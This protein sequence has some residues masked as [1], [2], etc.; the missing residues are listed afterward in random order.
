MAKVR[1]QFSWAILTDQLMKGSVNGHKFLFAGPAASLWVL[2]LIVLMMGPMQPAGGNFS[3]AETI[4][5]NTFRWGEISASLEA[6]RFASLSNGDG[7]GLQEGS[8]FPSLGGVAFPAS[9][10]GVGGA[11]TAKETPR[12]LTLE[13]AMAFEGGEPSGE[14]M[15][16]PEN[17]QGGVGSASEG[18]GVS[19]EADELGES[20]D[21][22]AMLPP[23]PLGSVPAAGEVPVFGSQ[24]DSGGDSEAQLGQTSESPVGSPTPE[25]EGDSDRKVD[26]SFAEE[27]DSLT[28]PSHEAELPSGAEATVVEGAGEA[29]APGS[30]VP[31][32]SAESAEGG[33]QPPSLPSMTEAGS[34]ATPSGTGEEGISPAQ[35]PETVTVPQAGQI[36]GE[37][38]EAGGELEQTLSE[39][40][41]EGNQTVNVSPEAAE[42][43]PAG[44]EVKEV[45]PRTSPSPEG[46]GA[47]P[48]VPAV[49]T[50]KLVQPPERQ[51][52]PQQGIPAGQSAPA[53][54]VA[55]PAGAG[56][57]VVVPSPSVVAGAAQAAVEKPVGEEPR[58]VFNFKYQPWTNVLEW[59]ASQAGLSLVMEGPPHGT[60]NY[61]DRR[62]YTVTEAIDLINS[63]LLTK[64][65]VLVRRGQML[66]LV[67]LED[68]IP[69]NLVPIVPES[70]LANRGEHE[71]VSI[72]VSLSRLSVEEAQQEIRNLLGPQGSVVVLPKAQQLLITDTAG[73]LRMIR[74]VLS[75]ADSPEGGVIEAMQV[76]PLKYITP[77]E[78]LGVLR[79]LLGIPADQFISPDGSLRLAVDTLGMRLFVAGK[80]N[81]VRQVAD[82]LQAV[83]VPGP[84]G[85]GRGVEGSLQLE[86]Y[87]VAPADPQT[88]LQVVQTLL[89]GSPGVRLATDA[90]TG[91]LIALARPSEHATI[92]A[93]LEQMR[94]QGTRLEVIPLRRL[95]PQV[96]ATAIT[97]LLAG[98]DGKTSVKV[99]VDS[100]ARQ[101]LV[102]GT[103]TELALVRSLLDK[104]GESG[105]G[106]PA[107]SQGGTVRVL[108]VYG[109]QA[110]QIVERLEQIWPTL[111]GNAIRVVGSPSFIQSRIPGEGSSGPGGP[112]AIPPG[113]TVPM[114]GQED[115]GPGR[116]AIPPGM[117]P[118][119]I[120]PAGAQFS[121]EPAQGLAPLLE[122]WGL[123]QVPVSGEASEGIGWP[124]PSPGVLPDSPGNLVPIPAQPQ[125]IQED[126]GAF[127][128]V[129]AVKP[130]AGEDPRGRGNQTGNS[131]VST[132]R[133]E[134]GN[135]V[136][137][138]NW[139]V[140][141]PEGATPEAKLSS[142]SSSGAIRET[143]DV[144]TPINTTP[145]N[146][147][148]DTSTLV[149]EGG[150]STGQEG[151]DSAPAVARSGLHGESLP[152][153]E[154]DSP[155][156][157][158][159]APGPNGL[160]IASQD[161]E[162]LDLLEELVRMMASQV[163]S[164]P[165]L[166][167]FYLKHARAEAVAEVLDQIFGGGTLA[168]SSGGAGGSMV[169]DLATAAFGEIGGGIVSSLLGGGGGTI[170]PSGTLRI[171]PDPRLN[172]LIVQA[173][174]VDLEIIDQLL[175][176][177]DQ[178]ESP[179]EVLAQPRP[180]VVP[181]YN[182][183][184]SEVAEIV[185]QVY[186]DRLITGGSQQ[187]R[188]G[189]P[190]PQEFMQMLQA[191]RG[192]RG[193]TTSRRGSM[194][195]TQRLSIGVDTRTNSVIVSAPEPLF[196]E[197]K[198]L[199]EELD[200]AAAKPP[201][202]TQV[203]VV[204]RANP[205]AVQQ[206]VRAMLGENV[207][208]GRS[209]PTGGSLTAG[210]T[211]T[212]SGGSDRSRFFRGSSNFGGPGG[213]GGFPGFFRPG[214]FFGGSSP[215]PGTPSQSST[216]RFGGSSSR[217]P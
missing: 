55:Q 73:R 91:N 111:R 46:E 119:A 208:I 185:K 58:L 166:T 11:V 124:W 140:T 82:I 188:G 56:V 106:G 89:A 63:V 22:E 186:Q 107:G 117:S 60:F 158:I 120:P 14:A 128:Q 211:G 84:E 40:K 200:A 182:M 100:L 207:A 145:E 194:E 109:V 201:Q 161:Q 174:P 79:Q 149:R 204:K 184:A 78:A 31:Y 86:V 160:V 199:I 70:E 80:A 175:Q 150:K 32:P 195:Q 144:Q 126:N 105:E 62:A 30:S 74:E 34:S 95:D 187:G 6:E 130:E 133:R 54:V 173:T 165:Q 16:S 176:V 29:P 13:I 125:P 81:R 196:Q 110:R 129:P 104:M 87:E 72:L 3:V 159:I 123:P 139:T 53:G 135:Q 205:E 44:E 168:G 214:G 9:L 83:D 155:A 67:N 172:A 115:R 151:A 183:Q 48:S 25:V 42:A 77:E 93:T 146:N 213:F 76:F 153:A 24:A 178:K 210:S 27:A 134:S 10:Q 215:Q 96:A 179:E 216:S 68:G 33:A 19:F 94:Q 217:R 169:R 122:K 51:G 52:S 147:P 164:G 92:R 136:R 108:P 38:T 142:G 190:N 71:L 177:L 206:A 57:P 132:R 118:P 28:R 162:A 15:G 138:V 193:G 2:S 66:I 69:P 5:S 1:T 49:P 148:E 163:S 180:R 209:T 59:L 154:G 103:E 102:R 85:A 127:R 167:I 113:W 112:G 116:P 37:A 4:R 170:T 202:A 35:P 64:G 143:G 121:P 21:F 47:V 171:T 181:V 36:P 50:P 41:V 65:Y 39:K 8:M 75:R 17:G 152:G 99:E 198:Q 131:V 23:P 156:P 98:Q 18:G 192:G 97:K 43:Q 20:E 61:S 101:L 191:L 212:S 137:L 197:V 88:V 90:K 189:P 12:V 7:R 26:E 157:I 45:A 141:E 203:V 114:P